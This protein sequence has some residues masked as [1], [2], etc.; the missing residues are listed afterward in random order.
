MKTAKLFIL[1][2][3]LA[4]SSIA[5]VACSSPSPS[6]VSVETVT[7]TIVVKEKLPARLFFSDF[8]LT[9]SFQDVEETFDV[10]YNEYKSFEVGDPILICL[11]EE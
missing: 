1:T 6:V 9:V 4:V 2:F 5:L 11:V 10:S 8:K 7:G 3:V